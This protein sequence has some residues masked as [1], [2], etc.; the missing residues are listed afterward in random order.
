MGM[1]GCD[2]LVIANQL[3]HSACKC[4]PGVTIGAQ[5]WATRAMAS[6]HDNR[7]AWLHMN[8]CTSMYTPCMSNF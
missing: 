6:I 7:T 5:L 3:S 2:G 8:P 1:N 4:R